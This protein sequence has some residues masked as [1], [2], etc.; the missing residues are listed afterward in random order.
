MVFLF[1]LSF[2]YLQYIVY[3]IR[4]RSTFGDYSQNEQG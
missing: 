3:T 2:S 1:V 4:E